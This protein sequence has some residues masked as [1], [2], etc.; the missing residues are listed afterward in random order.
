[1][2]DCADPMRADASLGGACPGA[3]GLFF[4]LGKIHGYQ[5]ADRAGLEV[6]EKILIG[7]IALFFVNFLAYVIHARLLLGDRQIQPD[8]FSRQIAASGKLEVKINNY[9]KAL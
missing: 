9:L 8:P 4:S 7:E 1:M 5:P 3:L 2:I 6:C